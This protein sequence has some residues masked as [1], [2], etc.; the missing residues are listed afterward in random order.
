MGFEWN[1]SFSLKVISVKTFNMPLAVFA[2][3]ILVIF[4]GR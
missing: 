4:G 1:H 3:G 2:C